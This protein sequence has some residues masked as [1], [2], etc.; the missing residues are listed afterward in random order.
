[1][2]KRVFEQEW[3]EEKSPINNLIERNALCDLFE[4]F[5]DI[6]ED[7]KYIIKHDKEVFNK[8]SKKPIEEYYKLVDKRFHQLYELCVEKGDD[9]KPVYYDRSM[10]HIKK[11]VYVQ[12]GSWYRVND[13]YYKAISKLAKSVFEVEDEIALIVEKLW[14]KKLSN[15]ENYSPNGE[16]SLLAH[17]DY[18]TMPHGQMSPKFKHY[19]ENQQG[20]CFS[21][22]C[23][24]KTRLFDT[25]Q[26][27]YNL[28][29]HPQGLV[30]II[31]KPKPG[32]IVGMA[33]D[34]MLSTEYIDGDC[35]LLRHFNHSKV[36]RCFERGNSEIYCRGT[37]ILPPEAIFEIGVDTINEIILDSKNI[38]VQAIF[39]VKNGRGEPPERITEYKKQQEK[40]CG[41][42][43]PVIELCPRNRMNQ[44]NLDAVLDGYY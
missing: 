17:V 11:E 20:L 2:S 14:I 42:K 8:L 37:K 5:R 24:K 33:Y 16:Y 3:V 34:D 21:Y 10:E 41:H 6:R 38:D 19:N 39:Y 9:G 29:S 43:L 15:I 22:V 31:A 28:Y 4:C 23:D 30:G 36:Y 35:A 18:K 25:S 44:V 26:S 27:Y 12:N 32:S 1:M 13:K 7:I 40:L